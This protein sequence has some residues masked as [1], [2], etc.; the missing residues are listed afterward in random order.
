MSTTTFSCPGVSSPAASVRP[1]AAGTPRVAKKLP[2]TRSPP[3]RSAGP[4]PVRFG[5]QFPNAATDS[6]VLFWSR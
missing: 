3:T 1:T 5:F 6:S 4:S 2:D